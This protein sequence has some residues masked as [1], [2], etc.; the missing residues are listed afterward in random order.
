M[1]VHAIKIIKSSDET[2]SLYDE[3]MI[4][5][6]SIVSGI[7]ICVCVCVCVLQIWFI[8]KQYTHQFSISCDL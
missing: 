3:Q 7:Y 2:W 8:L 6:T 1:T 5:Y 4:E